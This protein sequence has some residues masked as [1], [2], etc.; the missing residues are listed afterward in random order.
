[1]STPLRTRPM[2]MTGVQHFVNRAYR[3]S[4]AYQWAREAYINAVEADAS[5][6]YFGVEWQ[7]VRSKGVYRRLI[8][9][10]G[11]SID[12]D[13]LPKFFNT[14]GGSGKP[15]GDVHENF[16]VGFKTS[17][18][19]WNPYGVVVIAYKDA[20]ASMIWMHRDPETGEYGLK[21]EEVADEDGGITLETVYEPYNDPD[22]GCDWAE[23][24]PWPQKERRGVVIVLLGDGPDTDTF[25]G[26]MTREEGKIDA[27]PR[28]FNG[29]IWDVPD[30]VDLSALDFKRMDKA[31]WGTGESQYDAQGTRRWQNRKIQGQK[32]YLEKTEGEVQKGIVSVDGGR[33]DIMWYLHPEGTTEWVTVASQTGFV[34]TLYRNELYD[35]S[36]NHA[37]FWPFGI[38]EPAVRKRV[39]LVVVPKEFSKADGFGAYPNSSRSMVLYSD[40]VTQATTLPIRDWAAEFADKMPEAIIKAIRDHRAKQTGTITDEA[41]R[42]KLADRFG[43]R[44]RTPR[45]RLAVDGAIR[46]VVAQEGGSPHTSRVKRKAKRHQK[47]GGAGQGGTA[48]AKTLGRSDAQGGAQFK[49]TKVAVALPDF[50][51]K[52][53]DAFSQGMLA[54]WSPHEPDYPNGCVFINV[55]H[56]VIAE[57][58]LEWQKQYPQAHADVVREE[59]CQAYGQV[60]VAHIAHSEHL[61]GI[62]TSDTIEQELRSQYSLT[63]ALLGLWPLEAIIRQRLAAKFPRVA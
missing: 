7:A 46:G 4:T 60:A 21:V 58:I 15:I 63:M 41:W 52:A 11:A 14:F 32:Y 31:E 10:D 25:L 16:G 3:E 44:W 45:L 36:S 50:A 19:P 13:Q 33:A 8:A 27:L 56:P 34:A 51:F 47:N 61:K 39:A 53:A 5:T 22:H 43:N 18:L 54:L 62:I 37:A 20:D 57:E 38:T 55:E 30:H 24:W 59:V 35:R 9:D 6:I 40:A 29:R 2:A 42:K 49:K 12:P 26:D 23:V 28:Y 48:G 1:M 17:V